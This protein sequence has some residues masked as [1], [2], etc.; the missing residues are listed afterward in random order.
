MNGSFVFQLLFRHK[1]QKNW[2][3]S[4]YFQNTTR[5]SFIRSL[6]ERKYAPVIMERK[7]KLI[8]HNF[9]LEGAIIGEREMKCSKMKW[10]VK[11]RFNSSALL[12]SYGRSQVQSLMGNVGTWEG[13]R[14]AGEAGMKVILG[15]MVGFNTIRFRFLLQCVHWITLAPSFLFSWLI[16]DFPSCL[17]FWMCLSIFFPFERNPR[18]KYKHL[19]ILCL[20]HSWFISPVLLHSLCFLNVNVNSIV[21]HCR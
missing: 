18:S 16:H 8:Q 15:T 19:S 3:F 9:S 1:H 2:E 13:K 12:L 7:Q 4:V 14:Q 17:H 21:T 10:K 6:V 20:L 5:I 11:F